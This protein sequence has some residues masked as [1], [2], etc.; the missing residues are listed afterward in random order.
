MQQA[1]SHLSISKQTQ[2]TY[3][4]FSSYEGEHNILFLLNA[5]CWQ[6]SLQR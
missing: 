1:Q 3:T 5:A 4:A 6:C 2:S